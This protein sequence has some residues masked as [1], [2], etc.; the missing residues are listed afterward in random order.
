MASYRT[1]C[2]EVGQ[3]C[4]CKFVSDVVR[5]LKLNPNPLDLQIWLT[6]FGTEV[7]AAVR[8]PKAVIRRGA[9]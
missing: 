3:N 1:D 9:C 5:S 2:L 4:R 8:R 7:L 6:F